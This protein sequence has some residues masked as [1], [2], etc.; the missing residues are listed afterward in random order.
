M[1][2][3]PFS[4]NDNNDLYIELEY[5]DLS[6][7]GDVKYRKIGIY[8]PHFTKPKN[9]YYHYR[10]A[11]GQS[12]TGFLYLPIKISDSAITFYTFPTVDG[13]SIFAKVS[14]T[15][16]AKLTAYYKVRGYSW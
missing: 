1:S 2:P 12:A 9:S 16:T 5:C 15:Y 13:T 6:N 10:Y 14:S 4:S 3:I 7:T 11:I 8:I